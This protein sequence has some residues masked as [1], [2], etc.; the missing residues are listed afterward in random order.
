M[1]LRD[2]VRFD[3]LR[4]VSPLFLLRNFQ[5]Y[6]PQLVQVV[7]NLALVHP[8][9]ETVVL[10]ER[11]EIGERLC[12]LIEDRSFQILIGFNLALLLLH[13]LLLSD[14]LLPFPL[15]ISFPLLFALIAC[16]PIALRT[17]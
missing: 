4:F 8:K 7:S 17:Q 6:A 5:A 3:F 11:L 1:V 14:L 12:F 10:K 9:T 15:P 13:C 16:T 2:S